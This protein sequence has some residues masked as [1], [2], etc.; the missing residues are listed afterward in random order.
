VHQFYIIFSSLNHGL[1]G[2]DTQYSGVVG[3]QHFGG[4][5]CLISGQLHITMECHNPEDHDLNFNC[6]KN[7]KSVLI[8]ILHLI[9]RLKSYLTQ[10]LL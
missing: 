10:T 6:H 8:F 2:Y 1:L 7:L 5:C 4:P 9:Y 3:Y